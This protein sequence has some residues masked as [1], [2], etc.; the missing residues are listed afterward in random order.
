[1]LS[2]NHV[3]EAVNHLARGVKQPVKPIG[4]LLTYRCAIRGVSQ[5]FGSRLQ[6]GFLD[7]D[8]VGT[9]IYRSGHS[10]R[11]IGLGRYRANRSF[12]LTYGDNDFKVINPQ[13]KRPDLHLR[14]LAPE[15]PGRAGFG[16]Q[17]S[18]CSHINRIVFGKALTG[19]VHC[20]YF[21]Q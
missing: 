17:L 1:M 15:E 11:P 8:T 13:E 3:Q 16:P 18:I 14:V 4:S 20:L 9:T 5:S 21:F 2:W 19:P 7:A 6:F 10:G 12:G